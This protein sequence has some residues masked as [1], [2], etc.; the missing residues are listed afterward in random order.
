MTSRSKGRRGV[1]LGVTRTRRSILCDEGGGGG[2]NGQMLCD[3]I[4]KRPH[5]VPV[6]SLK[7]TV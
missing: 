3:G 5:N 2:K 6:Y 4:Y 1:S 7:R